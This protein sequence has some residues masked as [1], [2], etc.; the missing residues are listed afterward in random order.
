MR[1]LVAAMSVALMAAALV[2]SGCGESLV[3]ANCAR[4]YTRAGDRCV[5]SDASLTDVRD[6]D[7]GTDDSGVPDADIDSGTDEEVDSCGLGTVLCGE[8]CVDPNDPD[9]CGGCGG[10]VCSGGT[11]VCLNG[12]CAPNCNPQDI[13]D[14]FCVDTDTDPR[15]CGNCVTSCAS[16]VC[17]NGMC[18]PQTFGLVVVIGHDYRS[19]VN[20]AEINK[21]IGNAVFIS[22]NAPVR[23]LAYEEDAT[24]LSIVGTDNAIDDHPEAITRDWNKT[25]VSDA[26]SV[27]FLLYSHNVFLIY[28]QTNATNTALTQLGDLWETALG[29]FIRRGGIIVLLES[30]SS[31]AGTYQLLEAAGL[32]D[33]DA[34]QS[35]PAAADRLTLVAGGDLVA[36]SGPSALP[37]A[38][39][40]L[41]ETSSF[42]GVTSPN[43]TI[44]VEDSVT[45]RPV[46]T[47]MAVPPAN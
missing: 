27:P 39:D 16:N 40:S 30:P 38:F 11:P 42:T 8:T 22:A 44:V 41:L 14:G 6:D 5:A 45:G 18:A 13:C 28:A 10:D 37:A 15:Y 36:G 12:T 33:A 21:V 43:T 47:H 34:R 24:A 46:V 19:D 17:N 25:I 9:S 26:N 20:N 7:T 3:G 29:E 2:M 35:I 23:L 31:N 32:F 1:R 4:G